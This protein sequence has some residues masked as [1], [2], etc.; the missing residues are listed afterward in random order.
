MISPEVID[1]EPQLPDF[2]YE[3]KKDLLEPVMDIKEQLVA[4]V[5]EPFI[6]ETLP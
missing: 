1:N 6:I 5:I 2:E 4:M 3:V